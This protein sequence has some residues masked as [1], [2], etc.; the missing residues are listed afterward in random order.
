MAAFIL[1]LH[2]ELRKGPLQHYS[3]D[4][5]QKI[6]EEYLAWAE[7][8]R[9]EGKLRGGEELK[10]GGRTVSMMNGRAVDG[11]FAETKEVVGGYFLIE[12]ETLEAASEMAKGCPHVK[13]GGT[14]EVREV[15]PH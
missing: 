12:E 11:P 14:I 4:E 9:K 6:V 5:L 1:L 13:Y 8:L 7:K 15:N 10:D 3:A 2:G